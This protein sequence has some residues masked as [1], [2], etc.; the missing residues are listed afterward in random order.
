MPHQKWVGPTGALGQLAVEPVG[1][2]KWFDREHAPHLAYLM[3]M[4]HMNQKDVL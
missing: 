3:K 2:E 4:E 1:T